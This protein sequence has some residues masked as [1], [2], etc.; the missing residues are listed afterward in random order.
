MVINIAI[1]VNS[2]VPLEIKIPA[3]GLIKPIVEERIV[4]AEPINIS[5]KINN[6][7]F[8]INLLYFFL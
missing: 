5:V 1:L 3:P 8:L 6:T 7:F 4:E 2:A